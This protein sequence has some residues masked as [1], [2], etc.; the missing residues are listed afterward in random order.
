MPVRLMAMGLVMVSAAGSLLW[1][2]EDSEKAEKDPSP[3]KAAAKVEAKSEE[4]RADDQDAAEKASPDEQA[5][6]RIVRDME[7]AFNQHDAEA[8][9]K[10]FSEHGEVIDAGGEVTQGQ[11]N[12][13]GIF[14]NVFERT[15]DV[16]MHVQIESIRVLGSSVAVEEGTVHLIEQPDAPEEIARYA[17]V[18]SK[19]GDDW[20]MISA[21][22]LPADAAVDNHLEQLA[23][24]VGDWIDEC[25][26]CV[27]RTSYRWAENERAI[28]GQFTVE[29]RD[30]GTMDGTVHI[31]WDPQVKQLRSWI[32]DSEGGFATGL[33]ARH[34]DTWIVKLNGTLADG[35]T[36]TATQRIQRTGS[37]HAE[38]ESRDRVIG[39]VLIPDGGTVTM[40]R[41]GPDPESVSSRE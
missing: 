22:D 20:K 24:L 21:R 11:E 35:H 12:I 1:S 17:V 13:A 10:L 26:E 23:W 38:M 41:R 32:F 8:I 33:W 4:A 36:T 7:E 3:K 28:L 6:R 9:V 29:A 37:D 25:E 2:A 15:P 30:G 19:E 14:A 31:G 34:E 18:Y 5:I 40:V 39:G 27:V 16:K